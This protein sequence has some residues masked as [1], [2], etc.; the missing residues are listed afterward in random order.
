MFRPVFRP[1][2]G[3]YFLYKNTIVVNYIKNTTLKMAGL[4]ADTFDEENSPLAPEFSF[5]F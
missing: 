5:K 4:L 3:R 2:S 1:S